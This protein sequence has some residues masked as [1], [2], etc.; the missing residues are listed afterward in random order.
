MKKFS[1]ILLLMVTLCTLS[2]TPTQAQNY[3]VVGTVVD[4]LTLEGEPSATLRVLKQPQQQPADTIPVAMGVTD[5]QGRFQLAIK[6]QGSYQLVVTSVGRTPIVRPFSVSSSSPRAE[7][8]ELLISEASEMLKGV[9]VVAQKPLVKMDVDELAYSV[10]DDPD[11][12]SSTLL[13]MLRKV[14]L[15]TVDGEDNIKVNGS[16]SFQI[17]VNGKPNP[18]LSANPSQTFKAIPANMV[19]SVSVITNPGAK[20]DAEGVGG[21][22]NIVFIGGDEAMEG[23]S[24]NLMAIGGT[25]QQ[26][27]G[28]YAM[29]QKGRLTL[30]SSFNAIHV[31]VKDY[32]SETLQE[33]ADQSRIRAQSIASS[34]VQALFGNFDVTY[35]MDTLN[36]LS[37]SVGLTNMPQQTR[38]WGSTHYLQPDGSSRFGYDTRLN[39]HAYNTAINGSLDYRHTFADNKAHTLDLAYHI[40]TQPH[41]NRNASLFSIDG[42]ADAAHEAGFEDWI[43]T[44]RNNLQE[45]TF[46][47][48]YA[49]P[50]GKGQT[51]ETGAKYILRRGTSEVLYGE[52]LTPQLDYRHESNIAALYSSYALQHKSFGLKAGLRYEYTDQQV[53]YFKGNGEDFSLNYDNLVPSL[54][55]S[56]APAMGQQLG[57]GYNMR[58]SRPGIGYLN[59]FVNDQDPTHITY[60]NPGLSAEKAHNLNLN[61][62]LFTGLL[63]INATLRHSFQSNSIE[64]MTWKE[65]NDVLYTTYGNIGKRRNTELN[66]FFN[67]NL[68]PL[69]RLTLNSATSYVHLQSPSTGYRNHGWQ[70]SG[71]A[72]LQQTLP[73]KLRLSGTYVGNS[74]TLTLQGQTSGINM[75]I[76]SLTKSFL[77]E[78]RM[79]VSV[80]AV[81]PFCKDLKIE[82]ITRG[83]DFSSSVTTHVPIR[84]FCISVNLRLGNLKPKQRAA[85]A[86][87]DNLIDR[88]DPNDQ[89]NGMMLQQGGN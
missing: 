18:M 48:D 30:S 60:G 55:L 17:F 46:Q 62:S 49:H 28:F 38:G 36:T 7:L 74:R 14:P 9:E 44:D 24:L 8:G 68:G 11:S 22:L 40:S 58:I 32:E 50:L 67:L 3:S 16:S 84:N 86:G 71:M 76:F 27:G 82:N 35:E 23:Y 43:N 59:P 12:K 77:K 81:N 85:K 33:A 56:Y 87:N 6:Q 61:Y 21:V 26:G 15:V 41:K 70:Q 51:L 57:A 31:G 89:M 34:H 88:R 25:R 20:Y 29:V 5:M 19:K 80:V 53:N 52:A 10:A 66:L 63:M 39:N 54:S 73:W 75:H 2:A 79:S 42:S 1:A 78:D 69:T 47:A 64:E 72:S 83:T 45:H 65:D 13:D 4:S 37:A